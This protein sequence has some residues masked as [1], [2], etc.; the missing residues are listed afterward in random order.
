MFHSQNPLIS[1]SPNSAV[2]PMGQTPPRWSSVRVPVPREWGGSSKNSHVKESRCLKISFFP[3]L[4]GGDGGAERCRQNRRDVPSGCRHRGRSSGARSRR[5]LGPSRAAPGEGSGAARARGWRRRLRG[6]PSPSNGSV[7]LLFQT[8]GAAGGT[9][10][11]NKTRSI[12]HAAAENRQ[13][14][15]PTAGS[16][17]DKTPPSSC[18]SG[19]EPQRAL[20]SLSPGCGGV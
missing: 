5:P 13:P 4:T 11:R 1:P 20:P 7:K 18:R 12:S 14:S 9:R 17:L 3:P 2:P 8:A 16:A 15:A 19:A 10:S 6:H